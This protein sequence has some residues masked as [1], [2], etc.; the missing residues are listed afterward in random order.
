M[1]I[2]KQQEETD[3]RHDSPGIRE[4][5][6]IMGMTGWGKSWFA[7]LY[8]RLFDRRLIYDPTMTFPVER[9]DTIDNINAELLDE[10]PPKKFNYGFVDPDELPAAGGALFAIGDNLLVIEECATVFDKGLARLPEW[11]KRH[12]FY[13]RHRS[14][15]IVL[16][17][18]RPTYMPID[19][20]SQANRVVTF[21][22]HEGA[23]MNWLQDFYGKERMEHMLQLPKFTCMDWHNGVVKEYSIKEKVL[24]VFHVKLD[25]SVDSP[26]S[27]VI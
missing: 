15:S 6:L 12:C 20:R 22:Q 4:I 14:C 11:G 16:I 19:F 2:E 8:S 9:Y 1:N 17:A 5:V 13:G 27:L 23:D 3:G 21:C 25:S 26:V 10:E 18:Q 24:E 7:K